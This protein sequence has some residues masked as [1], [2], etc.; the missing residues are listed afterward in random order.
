M[1][2]KF[3]IKPLSLIT[4]SLFAAGSLHAGT[5]SIASGNWSSNSTWNNNVPVDGAAVGIVNGATVTMQSGD[6]YTSGAFPG[7]LTIGTVGDLWGGFTGSG[8]GTLNVTGGNLTTSWTGI[9]RQEVGTLNIS[10]GAVS[11]QNT[12]ALG[13][14]VTSGSSINVSGG[15]LTLSGGDTAAVGWGAAASLNVSGTGTVNLNRE[16]I[17]QNASTVGI[18]GGS[19]VA[20]NTTGKLNVSNGAVTQSG[21]NVTFG[22]GEALWLG[23]GVG[24]GTY[25]LSGGTFTSNG[26]IR[27]GVFGSGTGIFNQS[28]GTAELSSVAGWNGAQAGAYNLQ[29]GTLK[30]LG[31]L[32]FDNVSGFVVGLNITGSAGNVTVDTNGFNITAQNSSTFNNAAATLNKTGTGTLSIGGGLAIT[33]GALSVQNGTLETSGV[34]TLGNAGG[35]ATGSISGGTL[36]TGYLGG[37]NFIVGDGGTGTVT[38]TAGAVDIGSAANVVFGWSGTGTYNL[39]G[40]TFSSAGTTYVGL[41][42]G[43]VG[44]LNLNSGTFNANNLALTAGGAASGILNIAGGSLNVSGALSVE[45][46]GII[47]VNNG[48]VL[49]K[50]PTIYSGGQLNINNG[51]VMNL[52]SGTLST[53]NT[54]VNIAAGGALKLGGGAISLGGG[55][56]YIANSGTYDVNGQT[57]AAGSYEAS[58][59]ASANAK[60]ANSSTNA[61]TILGWTGTANKNTV[62]V[63]S[64]GAVIETVGDLDISSILTDGGTNNG[65]TKTGAGTLTLSNLGNS[66]GSGNVAVSAGTLYLSGNLGAGAVNVGSAGTIGG[67]GTLTGNLAFASGADFLFNPTTTLTVNGGT[68]SFG[69]FSVADLFGLTNAVANDTYTLI[70]GTATFNFANVSNLGLANAYDLGGGKKAYFQS[71]SM[72]LVV[73]P[74]P[75]AALLGSLGLLALLRRRRA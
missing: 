19:F 25:N 59:F 13:W 38:Q 49:N 60:L 3:G 50:A 69:G 33:N 21:G 66:V 37:S 53:V 7:G 26:L 22:T 10:G 43:G 6:S 12:L 16:L 11:L 31:N 27:F 63:A 74:E 23:G 51:G 17:V 28:G 41:S 72:N 15:S 2:P 30:A 67:D 39:N 9:G 45:A 48:G 1:K 34:I 71:G 65:F 36:K 8:S 56:N 18:S 35:T 44:T 54:D 14:E 5:A 70:N 40:G 73:I 42:G 29:G 62:W 20:S 24:T 32:L 64:S 55:A 46:N 52:N 57:V 47:N 4:L 75:R 68:V 58:Y 61:A